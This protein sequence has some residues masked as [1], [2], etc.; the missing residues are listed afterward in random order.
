MG[1]LSSYLYIEEMNEVTF[2]LCC[3]IPNKPIEG[4][5]N[6]SLWLPLVKMLRDK[7][8]CKDSGLDCHGSDLRS[9]L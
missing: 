2:P 4:F 7:V 9:F 3:W 1:I 5:V 8:A 6:T